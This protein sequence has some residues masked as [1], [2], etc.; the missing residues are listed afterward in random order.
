MEKIKI[1]EEELFQIQDLRERIRTNGELIGRL[2]IRKYFI[3]SDSLKLNQELTGAY[4]T[5]ED[6]SIEENRIVTELVSKY[7]NGD[8]NFVT[9]EYTRHAR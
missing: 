7:G 9:G 2:N 1:S 6:L 5:I 4:S 3:E 8:L